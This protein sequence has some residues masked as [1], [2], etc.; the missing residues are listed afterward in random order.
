MVRLVLIAL[1]L[2]LA[3]CAVPLEDLEYCDKA[4][5]AQDAGGHDLAID[6]WTRCIEG[7]D[8][9]RENRATAYNNRGLAYDD[10]GQYDRAIQDYDT[11]IRLDPNGPTAY[12]N[13]GVAYDGKGQYDRAIHDYD[14]AIRLDPS[15]PTAYN[16]RG[17]AHA[18]T[19]SIDRAIQDYDQA[20]RFD[21]GYALAYTNRG[22]AYFYQA[23]FPEAVPDLDRSVATDPDDRYAVIW[24]YLAQSRAGRDG[25]ADLQ[26]NAARFDL[27]EWP[28]PVI[29]M[30]LGEL[31][32]QTVYDMGKVNQ[33]REDKERRAE[34]WFYVGQHH[35]IAGHRDTAKGLFEQV[36]A[37]GS[38]DFIEYRGAQAELVRF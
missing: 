34:A 1:S 8:L 13:R 33:T 25:R 29:R 15:D 19:G 18:E 7:G 26:R 10:K 27:D 9:G 28:G 32:P 11:A 16:N 6:Y 20:I 37:T 24:L 35:L 21:P 17:G 31:E 2:V 4:L 30:F 3:A 12:N 36:I 5:G 38:T 14:A 23:R 22:R